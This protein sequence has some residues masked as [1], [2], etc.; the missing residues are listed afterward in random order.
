MTQLKKTAEEI[1]KRLQVEFSFYM[2]GKASD[3]P[4]C[5]K[6]FEK[7]TDDGVYTYFRFLYK[8]VG[9]IGVLKGT[10]DIEKNYAELLP[11]YIEKFSET[12]AEMTKTDYLRRILS[13]EGSSMGIYKYKE[14]YSLQSASCFAM[15]IRAKKWLDE[16]IAILE[17]YG[18]NTLDTVV[19]MDE[20][21]CVLVKFFDAEN[22]EYCSAIDYAEFLALSV[23]EELGIDVLVGVGPTVADLKDLSVSYLGAENTLRYAD[24]FHEQGNVHSYREFLLVKML[25][26]IPENTLAE[27][28]AEFAEKGIQ[29]I[30]DDEEMVNTAEAFLQNSLNVSE[31]SRKLYMHRNTLL[32]RLDKIEKA[33]GLNVRQFADAVS[34]RVLTIMYKLQNK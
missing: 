31:T 28:F 19:K 13:G 33:T 22:G 3:G 5:D 9:Y 2:E 29:E 17:Q 16:C 23:K 14:K 10:G 30:L 27:Y 7:T 11:A 1:A 8:N 15:V 20:G 26:G 24:M 21:H 34:F 25:E 6:Q 4:Y 12:E 18:G 32:Y